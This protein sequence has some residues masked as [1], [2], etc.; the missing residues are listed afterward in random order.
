ML[1]GKK[2]IQK[3]TNEQLLEEYYRT[4]DVNYLGA[5]Y[6]RFIPLVVGTCMKYLKNQAKAKDASMDIYETCT[7]K[8][9]NADV[10]HFKSW[11]YVVTKNHCLMQLRK[12][13]KNLIHDLEKHENT[14]VEQNGYDF[15]KEEQLQ[16]LSA[17]LEDLNPEQR[18]CISLF[19]LKNK[20]YQEIAEHLNMEL[21]KVKSHIQNGKRNLRIL[22][23][24]KDIFKDRG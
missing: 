15:V 12:D 10:H 7:K 16:Q 2:N 5:L 9:K 6:H 3:L 17:V 21:K 22:L 18:D 19:Y 13:K 20:C 8:L 23:S 1:F 11:L 4:K 24:E 14:I